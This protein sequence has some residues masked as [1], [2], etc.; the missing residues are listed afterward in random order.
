MRGLSGKVALVTG[1]GNGIGRAIAI[2]L[3]EEGADIAIIDVHEAGMEVTAASVK[4]LGRRC[5]V[6]YGDVGD[7]QAAARATKALEAKLGTFDVLVNNAGIVRMAA[8]LDTRPEDWREIMRI[9]AEGV[10]NMLKVVV[11]GMVQRGGGRVVNLSSW[12][13]KAGRPYFGMYAAS[14]AAVLALTQALALEVA[15]HGVRVNAVCP[16]MIEGTPM[17]ES[18][19]AQS[20][21]LGVPAAKDRVQT[22]P[23]RR[24]GT[25]EDVAKVVA[26][27]ASDEAGYM[28]GQAINI[29]GGMWQ[30]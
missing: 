14:K 2:R 17:R 7:H 23:L 13:G 16:G 30:H 3:A 18:A 24:A 19:E 10:L 4:A 12:L 21:A 9:N 20:K 29:S 22:I 28:T 6:A 27:L 15:P 11:P 25:P 26:F 1:G 8:V 5:E